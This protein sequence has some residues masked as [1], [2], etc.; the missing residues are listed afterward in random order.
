MS[1]LVQLNKELT[2]LVK[3]RKNSQKAFSQQPSKIKRL[4]E[5]KRLINNAKKSLRS[6]K[7]LIE[8]GILDDL[9]GNRKLFDFVLAYINKNAGRINPGTIYTTYI[10]GPKGRATIIM[11]FRIMEDGKIYLSTIHIWK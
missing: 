2:E 4:E 6:E 1:T 11:A 3:L 10:K 7:A 5:V 9:T 8:I